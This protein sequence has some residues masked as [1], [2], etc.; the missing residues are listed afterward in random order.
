MRTVSALPGVSPGR[1]GGTR[2]ARYRHFPLGASPTRRQWSTTAVDMLMGQVESV[3]ETLVG[4]A[5]NQVRYYE[6]PFGLAESRPW[7]HESA[8]AL[9]YGVDLVTDNGTVGVTWIQYGDFGYGLHVVPCPVLDV[10][11]NEVQVMH[12]E[13]HEPWCEVQGQR[14]TR[15]VI[16]PFEVGWGDHEPVTAPVALTLTFAA[17]NRIA[18]VCGGWTARREAVFLTGDDIVVIWMPETLPELVPALADS[19][20]SG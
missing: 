20:L 4:R 13:D 14:I 2:A 6:M 17:G 18:L 11:T 16:H 10:R 8:H 12:V 1:S 9:G 19:L 7:D 15:T 5:L 3:A